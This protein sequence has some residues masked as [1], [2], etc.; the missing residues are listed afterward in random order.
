MKW[1]FDYEAREL[2]RRAGIFGLGQERSKAI[3]EISQQ[4][5]VQALLGL[6]ERSRLPHLVADAVVENV[7]SPDVPMQLV[8]GALGRNHLLDQFAI[9]V[10]A[11]AGKKFQDKWVERFVWRPRRMEFSWNH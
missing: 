6:A 1:L 4:G 11:A 2:E 7:N 8:A 9:S 3:T 10:S 5:G